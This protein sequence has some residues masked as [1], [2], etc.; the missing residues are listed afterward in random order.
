MSTKLSKSSI[1]LIHR[2]DERL[3]LVACLEFPHCNEKRLKLYLS[4]LILQVELWTSVSA[5]DL[6][7]LPD[8][9][10][11]R[12]ELL[13]SV[14]VEL[15]ED[16]LTLAKE[17]DQDGSVAI[18]VAWDISVTLPHSRSKSTEQFITFVPVASIVEEG[19]V[20]VRE[21]WLEPFT[22][23]QS[24][25][26]SGLSAH[27]SQDIQPTIDKRKSQVE[28]TV[29]VRLSSRASQPFKVCAA[30]TPRL[31]YTRIPTSLP[32]PSTIAVLDLEMN[33]VVKTKGTIDT[34]TLSLAKGEAIDMM[35]NFLPITLSS[36]ESITVFYNLQ[37]AL[38]TNDSF[39]VLT[40]SSTML[41]MENALNFDVLRIDIALTVEL[42]HH[43]HTAI[44]MLWTTNVDF[45]TACNPA[46]GAPTQTTQRT[47]RP[48]SLN[49]SR[50]HNQIAQDPAAKVRAASTSLQQHMISDGKHRST[51]VV[52]IS[53]I[54]PSTP[55]LVGTPFAWRVLIV[56]NSS[57][58]AKLAIVPIPRIQRVN[59]STQHFQKRHAPTAS[60]ASVALA[61]QH[62]RVMN[63]A[64]AVVDEQIL[65]ALHHQAPSTGGAVPAEVDLVSL[66]AELRIGP[67]GIGQC[68]ETEMKFAA[69][70]SGIFKVDAIRVVD[71][72]KEG[73]LATG[74]VN[75]ITA[76]PEIVVV[77]AEI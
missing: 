62:S 38:P 41:T 17:N 3:K 28:H 46:F 32:E 7:T 73:D 75:D 40:A 60:S 47:D 35:P 9:G 30:I 57:K 43:V 34:I 71:L 48:S 39:Q 37:H 23:P 65:Y 42:F 19:T 10:A 76:L 72:T 8:Q 61:S 44:R 15:P 55:I 1:L 13:S 14:D 29:S 68:Y 6:V 2:T 25:L 36:K 69:Y 77:E 4:K 24:T 18:V 27:S 11:F 45:S 22:I 67:L 53:F 21:D 26:M 51:A 58:V 63:I 56:N 64:K 16:P 5:T 70:K 59:N 74:A 66:T 50:Y 52:S 12:Q 49:Y 33:P 54:S 20:R 31:R